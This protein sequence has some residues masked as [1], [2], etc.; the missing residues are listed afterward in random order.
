MK[1][2]TLLPDTA[3]C[4]H[5]FKESFKTTS[6][7]EINALFAETAILPYKKGE[8]IENRMEIRTASVIFDL[9]NPGRL[10]DRTAHA[11]QA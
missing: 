9:Q 3:A 1:T 11:A 2:E 6:M 8:Y 4:A 10:F 7:L 5:K